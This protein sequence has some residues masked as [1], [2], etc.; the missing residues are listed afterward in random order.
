MA[1]IRALHDK[2]PT[3]TT[4]FMHDPATETY[5]RCEWGFFRARGNHACPSF[6][7]RG[8]SGLSVTGTTLRLGS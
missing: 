8:A 3:Q 7:Q 6:Q 4:L 1:A 2:P 5:M